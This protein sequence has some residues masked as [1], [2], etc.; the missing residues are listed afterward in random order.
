MTN[1]WG[2]L[3]NAHYIDCILS[4]LKSKPKL[5]DDNLLDKDYVNWRK[6]F[7]LSCALIC[8]LD[9]VAAWHEVC[10][11]ASLGLWGRWLVGGAL[12]A[13]IAYDDAAQYLEW[14]PEKLEI[15]AILTELPAPRLLLP[16]VKILNQELVH[17]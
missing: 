8:D 1:E 3:P 9:R 15:M 4:S 13:L 16:A 14:D 7:D 17:G 10:H 5:W 11:T 6:A 12:V 2:H